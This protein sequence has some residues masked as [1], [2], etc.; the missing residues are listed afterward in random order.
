MLPTITWTH[1]LLC[2]KT[3]SE[4]LRAGFTQP[5]F[6]HHCLASQNVQLLWGTVIFARLFIISAHQ[7]HNGHLWEEHF[8]QTLQTHLI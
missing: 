4:A 5:H 2:H 1:T 3:L 7:S 6:S 8:N